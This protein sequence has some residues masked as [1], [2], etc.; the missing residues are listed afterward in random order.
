MYYDAL[1]MAAVSA[2]LQSTV[3]SGRVQRVIQSSPLSIGLEIY[4]QRQ[5]FQLLA[6]AHPETGRVHLLEEKPTRDP[7]A[8]SPL[9]LHLRRRIRGSSLQKIESPPLERILFLHFFHPKMPLGEQ[10]NTLIIEVMGRHSNIILRDAAGI[11]LDCI[12]RVTP[13]MSSVRPML[14]NQHYQLPPKQIKADPR[15]VTPE[16][17][18]RALSSLKDS[19]PLD[20]ALVNLYRGIS[21]LLGREIVFRACGE[22]SIKVAEIDDPECLVDELATFWSWS[23]ATAVEPCLATEGDQPV[24]CAPYQ[25]THQPNWQIHPMPAI[26]QA[27]HKYYS[28]QR[29]LTGHQQTREILQK[30]INQHRE[31]LR[32][33]M[34]ALEE[35]RNKADQSEELRQKGEWLLAFQ[36]L[37][38]P[39]QSL[40]EIEGLAIEVDPD[41]S[42]VE[43]AQAYFAAYRKAKQALKILPVRIEETEQSLAWIQEVSTMLEL[44]ENYDE[45]AMLATEL[46]E[47]GILTRRRDTPHRKAALP[48]RSFQSEDGFTILVGRNAGQN[49]TLSLRRARPHDLWFHARGLSGAHVIVITRGQPVPERTIEQAAALAAYYSQGRNESRVA[50]DY[51]EC[52]H[53]RRTAPS[54]PGLVRYKYERTLFVTPERLSHD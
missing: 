35:E 9:L 43:N 5:R 31:Q 26:S 29:P 21:P 18:K 22:A 4:A 16:G 11:V 13:Q 54:R 47:A 30:A 32:K 50:V 24:A 20:R 41:K 52:R 34:E 14:P 48:P 44:A 39:D 6:S 46:E 25:I 42:P 17:L 40:L 19:I 51:T 7:Q 23:E 27:L 28:F 45:I 49:E 12:K 1:T 8:Q 37:L 2:E 33:Q 10:H 15:Q 3:L 53:V 38:K 36:H